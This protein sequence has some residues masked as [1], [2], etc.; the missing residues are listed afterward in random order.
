MGT[1][2]ALLEAEAAARDM[3]AELYQL[4]TD[5]PVPEDGHY[6]VKDH[7]AHMTAW[8]LRAVDVLRRTGGER[9][10]IDTWN[11]AVYERTKDQPVDQVVREARDSWS[12][13]IGTV[14][15]MTE[16][17]LHEIHPY[18]PELEVW[19]V[20]HANGDRHFEEHAEYIAELA[21]S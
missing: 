3:E 14:E 18:N 9:P 11:A 7:L 12:A 6:R 21:A 16:E 19:V 8:R 20:V 5:E 13:L 17:Q 10:N 15:A 4:A 1:R 2:E